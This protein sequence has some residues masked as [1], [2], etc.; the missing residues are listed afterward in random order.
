[1]S[2]DDVD[3]FRQKLISNWENPESPLD[4]VDE[5][6]DVETTKPP[7][8]V[9]KKRMTK[10]PKFAEKKPHRL[11]SLF[12]NKK[13]AVG[14]DMAEDVVQAVRENALAKE[15]EENIIILSATGQDEMIAAR[16]LAAKYKDEKKIMFVN[17][18]FKQTPRELLPSKTVYSICPLIAKEKSS[19][20]GLP[21]QGAR[22]GE[23]N[24][25]KVVVMRRYP[26]DWEIFVDA[27]HGFEL[28]ESV[29]V[30]QG[31]SRGVPIEIVAEC[32]KKFLGSINY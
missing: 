3:T 6:E 17:C 8:P 27:G 25:P 14:A 32:L 23:T 16:A 13:I 26:R 30:T 12:G 1:L 11:A 15:D 4:I 7:S 22:D 19:A 2:H 10:K 21:R 20:T 24:P 28:A 29:P 31:N 5:P 18:Q 9:P